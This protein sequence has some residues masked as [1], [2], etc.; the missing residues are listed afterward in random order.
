MCTINQ[1]VLKN[2]RIRRKKI[3]N[4][5]ALRQCPQKKGICVKVRIV[6]PKKPNSAQRKIV[7]VRIFK[8]HI[9]AK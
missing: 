5:K 3:C 9:L 6:K 8:R 2:G 7:K 1:L 4:V